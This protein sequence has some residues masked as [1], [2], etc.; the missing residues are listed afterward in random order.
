MVEASQN[1]RLTPGYMGIILE[2]SEHGVRNPAGERRV[3]VNSAES[4]QGFIFSLFFDLKVPY[5][6]QKGFC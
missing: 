5:N 4:H 1:D 3:R 2:V 6:Q